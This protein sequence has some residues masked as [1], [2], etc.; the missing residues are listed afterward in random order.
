MRVVT[1]A[2]PDV[3]APSPVY[4]PDG[5]ISQKSK[6]ELRAAVEKTTVE[7]WIPTLLAA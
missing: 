3:D 2:S 4:A 7:D 6:D 1:V 5:G